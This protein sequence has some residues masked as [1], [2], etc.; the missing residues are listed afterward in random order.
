MVKEITVAQALKEK[1]NTDSGV[2]VVYGLEELLHKNF[3]QKLKRE[4]GNY[5]LHYGDEV[6]LEKLL[7]LMGERSLFAKGKTVNV[8]WQAEKFFS[9]LKKRQREK[10]KNLLRRKVSNLLVFSITAELKKGDWNKEPYK[11]LSEVASLIVSAK[12]LNRTQI[13]NLIKKKFSKEGIKIPPKAVEYLLESFSDLVELKNELD[14]LLA[15]A[16][17]KKELTLEEIKELVEGNRKY[18]VFDFQNA[19]FA[20]DLEGSLKTLKGLL[21]GLTTYEGN[22]LIFQLEGLILSTTNRLLLIKEKTEGG[23]T[24]KEIA[25]EVGLYYPFQVS[26][27]SNWN[28]LWSKE[29]LLKLLRFLYRFDTNCKLKFLPPVSEFEKFVVSALG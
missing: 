23:K 7:E 14:K 15:Y 29:E 27:Y 8:I 6:D 3:L 1:L 13:A 26:Q 21:S 20:K 16:Y 12:S 9:K 5:N 11:T 18:T 2:I 17:G 25:K 28:N 10:L 24:L 19:F 22:A 4:F